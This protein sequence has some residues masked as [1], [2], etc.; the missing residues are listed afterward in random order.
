MQADTVGGP[1]HAGGIACPSSSRPSSRRPSDTTL[2]L[3]REAE[4]AVTPQTGPAVHPRGDG[5]LLGN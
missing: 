4:E 3:L 5:L 1:K 2:G